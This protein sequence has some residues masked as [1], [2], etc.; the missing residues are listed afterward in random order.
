MNTKL[1]TKLC[2]KIHEKC[3]VH[4]RFLQYNYANYSTNSK[5]LSKH[6][7]VCG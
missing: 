6:Q 3:Q 1:R 5:T 2:Q 7:H 4:I